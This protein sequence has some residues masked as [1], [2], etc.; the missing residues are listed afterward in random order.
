MTKIIEQNQEF[1]DLFGNFCLKF[2]KQV[3]KII[4]IVLD[5]FIKND[6]TK[7]NVSCNDLAEE[8]TGI[9]LKFFNLE[10]EEFELDGDNLFEMICNTGM[11]Y[12]KKTLFN[13]FEEDDSED[14]EEDSEDSKD[15]N[16]Y[17]EEADYED[18]DEWW[19]EECDRYY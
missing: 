18:N 5:D 1:K 13:D 17:E 10:E 7:D 2:Q 9:A 6:F 16:D 12:Y 15:E 4:L 11:E 8:I 19:D 3:L 14:L